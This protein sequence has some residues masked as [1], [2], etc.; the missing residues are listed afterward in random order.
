[1]KWNDLKH[2]NHESTTEG[3][4]FLNNPQPQT[5]STWVSCPVYNLHN[6]T[7]E[8]LLPS[9]GLEFFLHTAPSVIHEFLLKY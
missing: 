9:R 2:E 4:F 7:E 5:K 8:A 6:Q 3:F 1:M